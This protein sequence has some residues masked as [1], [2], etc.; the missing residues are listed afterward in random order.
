[1]KKQIYKNAQALSKFLSEADFPYDF[2]VFASF[3]A[4]PEKTNGI[5]ARLYLHADYY[6]S[7]SAFLD[8]IFELFQWKLT[9]I[10]QEQAGKLVRLDLHPLGDN[11]E[12]ILFAR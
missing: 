5:Y 1:M 6:T 8:K 11:Y 7:H 9:Q 4:L 2:Q 3:K 12:M 10:K